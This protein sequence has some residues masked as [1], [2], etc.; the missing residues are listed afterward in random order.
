MQWRSDLDAVLHGLC[1]QST[2]AFA[3]QSDFGIGGHGCEQR[4][5]AFVVGRL[6]GECCRVDDE[7][8]LAQP[9][10]V[11]LIDEER[12]RLETDRCASKRSDQQRSEEHTSELQ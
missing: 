11:A 7:E 8:R 10:L 9:W 5:D 6:S 3:G 4:F 2:A 1:G 12:A